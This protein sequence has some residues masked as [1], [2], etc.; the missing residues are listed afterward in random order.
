M[1]KDLTTEQKLFVLDRLK[2]G[3]FIKHQ[4]DGEMFYSESAVLE[5]I[6]EFNALQSGKEELTQADSGN[7]TDNS[8]I[9]MFSHSDQNKLLESVGIESQQTPKEQ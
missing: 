6:K 8:L 7:G 4:I 3:C 2:V 1:N 5:L 9:S